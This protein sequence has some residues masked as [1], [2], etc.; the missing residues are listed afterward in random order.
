M[1]V[2]AQ[3]TDKVASKIFGD[4]AYCNTC[5]RSEYLLRTHH[6]VELESCKGC[7]VAFKC[8]QCSSWNHSGQTCSFYQRLSF[9]QLF[10]VDVF[11]DTGNATTMIPIQTPSQS[12]TEMSSLSGWFD[13]FEKLQGYEEL[14]VIVDQDDFGFALYDASLEDKDIEKSPINYW[15]ELRV[16]TDA[17]SMS[18]TIANALSIGLPDLRTKTS[19]LIHIIGAGSREFGLLMMLE[20]L[21]HLF[22]NLRAVK[23]VLIGPNTPKNTGE[24]GRSE[25]GVHDFVDQDC[26]PQC[27]VEGR[28]KFVALHR[29]FYHDF[30]KIEQYATPD[31]AV[32]FQSG[33][34]Q[35]E[36]ELWEPTIQFLVD[37][38]IV[39]ACTTY[40]ENE[41]VQ[42]TNH[43]SDTLKAKI[44]HPYEVNKWRSLIQ[45]LE[46]AE[47]AEHSVYH[48]DYYWYMFR[49]QA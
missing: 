36:V 30:V 40:T 48:V 37:Q 38:D 34:T 33:R 6:N 25:V 5:Y 18:M 35:C 23:T 2:L 11:N 3:I 24:Y 17:S 10:A 39:T 42:E 27:T 32:L 44:I 29:G 47:G 19:L 1:V 49:G 45:L 41:A 22:P 46:T 7:H 14:G 31:L 4:Q 26:C 8:R 28:K 16:A 13:Y 21:L 20:E 12:F 15:A 43:L 9:E